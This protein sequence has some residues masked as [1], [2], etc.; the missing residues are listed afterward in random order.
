MKVIFFFLNFLLIIPVIFY[1]L[2]GFGHGF[3]K[4]VYVFSFFLVGLVV[5]SILPGIFFVRKSI[6]LQD[7]IIM[8]FAGPLFYLFFFYMMSLSI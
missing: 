7:F 6:Q 5:S 1:M 4:L 8:A 3:D 2:L